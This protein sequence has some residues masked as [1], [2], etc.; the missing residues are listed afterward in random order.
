[1]SATAMKTLFAVASLL[2]CSVGHANINV[3]GRADEIEW[4]QAKVLDQFVTV[5]PYTQAI[6]PYQQRVLLLSLPE[7]LALAFQ[8]DH[9]AEVTRTK[10]QTQRD[11]LDSADRVNLIIDF[12][13]KGQ[14][15]YNFT[16]SLANGIEDGI[17]SRNNFRNDWDGDW[18]HAVH[19]TDNGWSVEM[20]IPWT[21][22]AMDPVDGDTRT[23]GIYLDRVLKA[24]GER[25]AYPALRFNQS[26]FI[27][28]F[29][30]I[31]IPAYSAS[32]SHVYPYVSVRR[33]MVNG[34]TETRA[35]L[36]VFYK[37]SPSFQLIG[38]LNPDFGQVESDDLVVDFSAIEVFFSDKRPFFTENND[39]FILSLPDSGQLIYTR[40][41]GG[42]RDDGKGIA[43]IDAAVKLRGANGAGS[44]SYLG[45][46]EADFGDDL[47]RR[48]QVLRPK[49]RVGETQFGYTLL[50]TDR[51]FLQREAQVQAVDVTS[52]FN[53]NVHLHVQALQSQIDVADS[54]TRDNGGWLAV[55]INPSVSTQH[56]FELVNYGEELMLNDMGYVQ[57]S[58]LRQV[59]WLTR[60]VQTGFADDAWIQEIEWQGKVKPRRNQ[61]GDDIGDMARIT[62]QA[63]SRA[64][65]I[66]FFES[67]ITQPGEDDLI[68]RGNG[69]WDAPEKLSKE[70]WFES[71]RR[72]N[73]AWSG[74]YYSYEE[75]LHQS[76]DM[77]WAAYTHYFGDSFTTSTEL[78]YR[79]SPDWLIWQQG[80]DFNRYQREV[81]EAEFG[82]NWFPSDKHELRLKAQWLAIAADHG[83]AYQLVNEDMQA[84]GNAVADLNIN[85]FGLQ[86]RYRYKLGS[87]SD[88]FAVYSRGGFS[89]RE[90]GPDAPGPLFSDALE[91]RDADQ[92]L[93]K[94]RLQF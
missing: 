40:R 11:Q 49:Y 88:V 76:F 36:D 41:I 81:Y 83:Q 94:L 61:Q 62:M 85:T 63:R 28:T 29:A 16:V 3:D 46:Q 30:K 23:V 10:P 67:V 18:Q 51:P 8:I 15:A 65:D 7:G 72:D 77:Y 25:Y 43:D 35:G 50:Q 5:E 31:N 68:S 19:E 20:L 21:I 2:L 39:D 91:L 93:V 53:E 32:Q 87:L 4:Q 44:I 75:G 69:N 57:R 58:N 37:P 70:V 78:K 74:G 59:S 54:R 56:T 1:M 42:N 33:D 79:D 48:F 89:E 60:Y 6:P 66:A 34:D 17:A 80:I 38:A 14:T 47:G 26:D 86:L 90:D 84:T 73:S 92:F 55:D 27:S 24:R 22:A 12:D 71:A 13:N 9:P 45:A 64:G 82:L 52:V